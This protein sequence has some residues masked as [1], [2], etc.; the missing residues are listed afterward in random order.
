M[1]FAHFA[2]VAGLFGLSLYPLY[3]RA[4]PAGAR[5]WT[6]A[7]AAAALVS[8]A[9]WFAL[10]TRDLAGALDRDALAAMI[11]A[12]SFGKVSAARLIL[13]AILL[14]W[15]AF[16]ARP[17]IAFATASGALAA[18]IALTGHTQIHQGPTL[19]IHSLSD[20]VH[21]LGAGAW[22][23]G[24][25]GLS[26][27]LRD[28]LPSSETAAQVRRFSATAYFAVAALV[29]S[30]LVNAALLVG[31]PAL[32]FA[33]GYGRLLLAKLALFAAMLALAAVNRFV[34]SPRLDAAD[35]ALQAR[36]LRRHVLAEQALGL[37]VLAL[38]AVL[39]MS[40]PP[41]GG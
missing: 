14:A 28:R 24:L 27:L 15:A 13:A 8:A 19:A 7:L 26:L 36:R 16:G 3:A 17:S 11:G 34:V 12:T 6:A 2:S 21:L 20:A 35:A 41:A 39:G 22:L 29:A 30:G 37:G 10:V 1:R 9:A 40:E 33:T 5:A 4:R 38:V 18:S 32:V 23:G 31:R 25:I